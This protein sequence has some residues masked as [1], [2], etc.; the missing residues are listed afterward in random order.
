MALAQLVGSEVITALMDPVTK[1]ATSVTPTV[2]S[3]HCTVS[4]VSP[5]ALVQPE[6]VPQMPSDD[7]L[8]ETLM[9]KEG[10]LPTTATREP[11][12]GTCCAPVAVPFGYSVPFS[13]KL[14]LNWEALTS[15]ATL[16]ESRSRATFWLSK[17]W[18]GVPKVRLIERLKVSVDVSKEPTASAVEGKSI[19]TVFC[20]AVMK[21]LG[22][23]AES[24]KLRPWTRSIVPMELTPVSKFGYA[25]VAKYT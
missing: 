18:T 25:A 6:P 9:L 12:T 23:F 19:L 4:P 7:S 17:S 15:R 1:G 24:A 8:T 13:E 3:A 16:A 22:N 20:M 11:A 2:N 21:E 10:S 14:T 5:K